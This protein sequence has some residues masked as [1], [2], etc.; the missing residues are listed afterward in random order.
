MLKPKLQYFG[1]LMQRVE[2]LGNILML[3]KIDGKRKEASQVALVIRNP[4]ANAG[5]NKRYGFEPCVRNIPWRRA[6]QPTSIFL[7]GEFHGQRNLV[8][9]GP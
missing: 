4:P 5:D 9:Y 3:G 7:P 8:G 1:H 2:S 6:W